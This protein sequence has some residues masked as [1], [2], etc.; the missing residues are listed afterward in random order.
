MKK[1]V[2]FLLVAL[3]AFAPA[4]AA[5]AVDLTFESWRPDDSENWNQ[6]LEAYKA[7]APDVNI[8][9]EG[10]T[11]K[12]YNATL[13]TQLETGKGPDLIMARS[14]ATGQEL[15]DAGYFGDCSDVAG[16][17]DSF[18]ASSLAPWQTVDGKMFAVP[19]AAVQQVVFFNKTFFQ[20]NGYEVPATWEDFIAL[21]QAIKDANTD[22]DFSP[23]ANG[24]MDEWD[25]LECAFLGMLPNYVGGAEERVKYESGEK[26][27]NDEAF[28]AAYT[29]FAKIAPF[30]PASY[31]AV[32]NSDSQQLFGLG[33][34][35]MWIDGSWSAGSIAVL[36][37]DFEWGVFA[38]PAPAGATAG[39]CFHPDFALTYNT[40]SENIDAAKDFLAWTISPEG[41]PIVANLLPGGFYPMVDM[42][43][44][45]EDEHANESLALNQGKVLDARFIWAQMLDLYDPM[46][47]GLIAL[48]SGDK[49]PQA[50][51]DEMA[52][53]YGK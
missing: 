23:L 2:L 31:T 44:T 51:A 11:S 27:L 40:A 34:A 47:K 12:E 15:F 7:V 39:L 4:M 19:T 6:I 30:L 37:P 38:I 33:R 9:H 43:I 41:A 53:L 22:P 32:G 45:L 18:A 14:Y 50:V 21:C 28:I 3:L 17:Q 42:Q 5:N 13:R 26:K 25:I 35:P 8:V 49:A 16:I 24:V 20:E 29:D 46:N 48:L 1:L 36:E 10:I 52:E